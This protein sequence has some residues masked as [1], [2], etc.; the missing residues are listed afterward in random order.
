MAPGNLSNVG[1]PDTAT[2]PYS[3]LKYHGGFFPV[4]SLGLTGSNSTG[5]TTSRHTSNGNGRSES[6]CRIFIIFS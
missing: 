5:R 4:G 2:A 3:A 1:K 6:F